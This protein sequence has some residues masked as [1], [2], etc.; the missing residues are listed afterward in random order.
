MPP[1]QKPPGVSSSERFL[2]RAFPQG[3]VRFSPTER[4][5][6][7]LGP[8]EIVVIGAIAVML[9]GKRLPEVGRSV[10]QSIGEL[11]KQFTTLQREMDISSHLDPKASSSR[12][13][14]SRPVGHADCA[15]TAPGRYRLSPVIRRP[16]RR[17][18]DGRWPIAAQPTR[19]GT[20][21]PPRSPAT[22]RPGYR[23]L[24]VRAI[25]TRPNAVVPAAVRRAANSPTPGCDP[26]PGR[27]AAV[28]P[29]R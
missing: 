10:G 3:P 17:P 9:Y 23:D 2:F 8:L 22:V 6:F 7:G 15:R 11:R 5:M 24:P 29:T 4:S 21:R 26:G 1:W 27:R 14:G 28:P 18:P 13:P 25:G 20:D 16:P 12:R 19:P